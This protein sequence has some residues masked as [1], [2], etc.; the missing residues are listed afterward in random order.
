MLHV[1][2]LKCAL[3][4]YLSQAIQSPGLSASRQSDGRT[5]VTGAV[6]PTDE[7]ELIPTGY[8]RILLKP[9]RP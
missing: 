8:R 2:Q 3:R 6:E 7:Q 1:L 9:R 4:G 5:E